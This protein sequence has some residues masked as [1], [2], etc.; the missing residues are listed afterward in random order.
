MQASFVNLQQS[1]LGAS[2]PIAIL[3]WGCVLILFSMK[4]R[5]TSRNRVPETVAASTD[6]TLVAGA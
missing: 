4:L 3:L 1:L 6:S 5:S 2:E